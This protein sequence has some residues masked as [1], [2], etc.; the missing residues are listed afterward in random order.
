MDLATWEWTCPCCGQR[1]RGIPDLAF[2]API[3]HLWAEQ[4][5]TSFEVIEKTNDLCRMHIDGAPFRFIR[6]VIE[7][8]IR[9]TEARIGFGVWSTLSE[10]N[11]AR[12]RD[13]FDD[14][15]QSKLGVMFGYLSNRLPAYPDTVNLKVSVSPRDGRLRPLVHLLD[16]HRDHPLYADQEHGYGAERLIEIIGQI[17][18]CDGKA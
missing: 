12:Y 8:P 11:F 14:E 17:L 16:D 6:C 18:P 1:K 5:D 2:D 4:G 15:D 13:S 3:Q 10:A 9:G 7:I